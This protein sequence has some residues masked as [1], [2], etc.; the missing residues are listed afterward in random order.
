MTHTIRNSQRLHHGS[1]GASEPLVEERAAAEA[2]AR[3]RAEGVV[4]AR[5]L[6]RSRRRGFIELLLGP[7]AVGIEFD[8]LGD[9][10]ARLFLLVG[11]AQRDA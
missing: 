4:V 10:L 2:R 6:Y 7:D 3:L 11:A 8:R 9:G 1:S 5:F